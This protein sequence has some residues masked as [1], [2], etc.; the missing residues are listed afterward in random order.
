MKIDSV[1]AVSPMSFPEIQSKIFPAENERTIVTASEI[2]TKGQRITSE[3]R[4]ALIAV[5]Q[6]VHVTYLISRAK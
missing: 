6:S 4:L 3:Y 1:F 2:P 5:D